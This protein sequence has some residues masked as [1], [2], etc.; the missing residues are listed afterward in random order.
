LEIS[1]HWGVGT[2]EKNNGVTIVFSKTLREVRISTGLGLEQKLTDA[3]CKKVI[4]ELMIPRFKE[5]NYAQGITDG[6]KEVIRLL[7]TP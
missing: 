3:M 6:L 7:E 1:Q 5:G 2:K 4:D